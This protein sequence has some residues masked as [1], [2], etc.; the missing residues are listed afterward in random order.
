MYRYVSI[1][2]SIIDRIESIVIS[3]DKKYIYTVHTENIQKYNKLYLK[4][5]MIYD[6]HTSSILFNSAIQF[7]LYSFPNI[8]LVNSIGV[9]YVSE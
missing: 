9:L 4:K 6:R 1:K 3:L 5:K 2:I 7:Y 8:A